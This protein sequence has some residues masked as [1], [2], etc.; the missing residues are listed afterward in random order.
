VRLR[1]NWKPTCCDGKCRLNEIA[2]MS[3]RD[4]QETLINV[5]DELAMAE[6]YIKELEQRPTDQEE[7]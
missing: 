2:A 7:E 5:E 3:K 1:R 6:A 4:L